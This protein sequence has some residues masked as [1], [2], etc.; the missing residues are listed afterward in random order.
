MRSLLLSL[1]IFG[2][3]GRVCIVGNS[4]G[5]PKTMS[6]PLS[7]L[8]LWIRELTFGIVCFLVSFLSFFIWTFTRRTSE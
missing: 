2:F 5:H 8:I 6:Q 1:L 3:M 7:H 4:F